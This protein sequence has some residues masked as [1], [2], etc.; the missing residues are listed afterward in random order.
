MCL[1]STPRK[2]STNA[3]DETYKATKPLSGIQTT[4]PAFPSYGM[5]TLG[6]VFIVPDVFTPSKKNGY[7]T[8]T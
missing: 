1:G 5:Y 4:D 3:G 8:Y 6:S 7:I 2:S